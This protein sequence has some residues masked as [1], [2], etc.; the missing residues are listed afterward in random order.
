MTVKPRQTFAFS[1]NNAEIAFNFLISSFVEDSKNGTPLE[2]CGWRSLVDV[3]KTGK[4]PRSSVYKAGGGQGAAIIELQKL[5]LV[6]GKT[7]SGERGRGG[8][9]LKLRICYDKEDVKKYFQARSFH[10][11]EGFA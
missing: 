8:N 3:M 10:G 9:I 6:E 4:V 2:G 7:F 5:G 1:T 11:K